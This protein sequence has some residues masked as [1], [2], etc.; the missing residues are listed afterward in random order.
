MDTTKTKTTKTMADAAE[1][2][3]EATMPWL[4]AGTEVGAQLDR[5]FRIQLGHWATA[6]REA[7]DFMTQASESVLKAREEARQAG[8]ELLAGF[9]K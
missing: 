9:G 8:L 5:F 2:A 3:R 7:A 1:S 4:S 6:Q